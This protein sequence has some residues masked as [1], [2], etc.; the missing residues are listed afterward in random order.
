M[1]AGVALLSLAF[2]ILGIVCG[3]FLPGPRARRW[4]KEPR[5]RARAGQPVAPPRV[6]PGF[7][8]SLDKLPRSV[9]VSLAALP[10]AL[11]RPATAR[12]PTDAH[13][14]VDVTP[15]PRLTPRAGVMA[16]PATS[17]EPRA[18]TAKPPTGAT[19]PGTTPPTPPA[20]GSGAGAPSGPS[21]G[22]TSALPPSRGPS[23]LPPSGGTSAQPPGGGTKRIASE[24]RPERAATGRGGRDLLGR[25]AEWHGGTGPGHGVAMTVAAVILQ[26]ATVC[27]AGRRRPTC[28][29]PAGR[30]ARR[31]AQC[32]W[33]WSRQTQPGRWRQP[34]PGRRCSPS[35][36]PPQA[37]RSRRWSGGH[38]W[39][40]TRSRRPRRSCRGRRAVLGG[41]R[42][43]DK[44]HRSARPGP[45][46]L[47]APDLVR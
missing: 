29:S 42:D 37:V 8:R 39:R 13:D 38:A 2:A 12:T 22:G 26:R 20:G 41:C 47:L 23:A 15:P 31:A 30:A 43:R 21:G 6:S 16:R 44:P 46:V 35:R 9:P 19:P 4:R 18:S 27:P 28:G 1:G 24:R 36:P 10:A 32:R 33:S 40:W 17:A 11:K 25:L 3:V 5:V 14:V 7:A 45:G 34:S